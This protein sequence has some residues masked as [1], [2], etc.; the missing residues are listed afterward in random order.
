M[1][2]VES[3]YGGSTLREDYVLG[4]EAAYVDVNVALD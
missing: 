3:R 2:R 4:A 1:L